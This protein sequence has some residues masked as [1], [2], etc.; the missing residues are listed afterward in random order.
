MNLIPHL[1]DGVP[2]VYLRANMY[3]DLITNNVFGVL[4]CTEWAYRRLV[5]PINSSLL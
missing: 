1:V 2:H 3:D 4:S 5:A